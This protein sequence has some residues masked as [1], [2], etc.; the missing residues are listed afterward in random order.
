MIGK[1]QA[2]CELRSMRAITATCTKPFSVVLIAYEVHSRN[3]F[4][5][6]LKLFL[7]KMH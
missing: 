4:A 3:L 1:I 7:E 2:P 6:H 5:L